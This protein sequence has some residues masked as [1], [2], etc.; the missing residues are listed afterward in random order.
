MARTLPTTLHHTCFLVHDV[1]A[2]AQRLADALG[3]GP[4][5]VFTIRPA[6]CRVRGEESPFTF[7]VALATVGGST[8][9]LVAP[10]S[11]DSVLD[12]HL[13][14]HGESHHHT[15]LFY[16]SIEAVRAAKADLIRQGRE[17][18]Q[19]ASAG[20][21]FDFT[22]FAFPEI[23]SLIEILF[24]DPSQLPPPEAVIHPTS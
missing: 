3:V 20:E 16:D 17:A 22:Y 15:C 7:R 18:I 10:D 9:E 21:A 11:G 6:I 24:L 4:W 8:F 13:A 23:G 2:T 14:R 12:E 5:H 19:E 1:E